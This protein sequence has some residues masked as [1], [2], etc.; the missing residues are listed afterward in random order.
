MNLFDKYIKDNNI[1]IELIESSN[2]T[3]TAKEA[4]LTHNIP[5][6]NIVKSLVVYKDNEYCIYLVPGN[7]RLDLD[8]VGGRMANAKEVKDITG[9][10][11]GGVPPFGHKN[12]LKIYIEDG[13]DKD[14]LL[15]AAGGKPNVVFKIG[16]EKLSYIITNI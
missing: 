3:S 12:R 2:S 15:L 14:N 1:D 6:Q 16:Y 8:R 13:F 9:Y 7:K 4:S 11:I 5:I 10:S